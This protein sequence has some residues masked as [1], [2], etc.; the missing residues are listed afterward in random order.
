MRKYVNIYLVDKAYG[1]PEE[2]GWWYDYGVAVGSLPFTDKMHKAA[3]E[4]GEAQ[5]ASRPNIS[6]VSSIGQYAVNIEEEQAKNF[7]DQ[8]PFYE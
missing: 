4:W 8:R 7:P 6:S 3:I 5:N 2:G 1:G